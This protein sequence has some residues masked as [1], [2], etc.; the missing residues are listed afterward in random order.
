MDKHI[1]L[2]KYLHGQL[3]DTEYDQFMSIIESDPEFSEDVSIESVL[4]AKHRLALK[5]SITAQK[6][7]T[8]L[9]QKNNSSQHPLIRILRNIAAIFVL[10]CIS[11]LCFQQLTPDSKSKQ[12]LVDTYLLETHPPPSTL[13]D[14]SVNGMA[15]W[16]LATK[17][18]SQ[19]YYELTIEQIDKITNKNNEQQLYLGLSKL[20]SNEWQATD[21]VSHFDSIINGSTTAHKD[22]AMWYKSLILI[23]SK[24]RNEAKVILQTIVDNKYW[25]YKEAVQLLN[26][27]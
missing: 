6:V 25:K 22:E 16:K 8:K 18:Y 12:H 10:A 19:K 21:A 11:Y 13:R 1:L 20:Y 5:K 2:Q 3:T 14:D 9:P 26:S 24:K 17:A 4:Y 27:F 23:Q 7:A 15:E